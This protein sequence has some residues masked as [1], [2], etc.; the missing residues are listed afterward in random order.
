MATRA[1]IDD[2][3]DFPETPDTNALGLGLDISADDGGEHDEAADGVLVNHR[4]LMRA[5]Y[6]IS[7]NLSAP[8][9]TSIG[10][11]RDSCSHAIRLARAHIGFLSPRS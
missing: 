5:Y 10:F 4:T 11:R 1:S 9:R 2:I 8:S 7:P 3:S 6:T